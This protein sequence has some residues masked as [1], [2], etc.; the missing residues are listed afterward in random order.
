[1]TPRRRTS[2]PGPGLTTNPVIAQ[3]LALWLPLALVAA[4]WLWQ[5][6]PVG[7]LAAAAML[8]L[9]TLEGVTVAVDQLFGYRRPDHRVGD[10]RAS[11]LFAV[12]TVVTLVPLLLHLRA[13]DRHHH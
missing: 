8:T 4:V 5:R 6:R 12:L 3:D 1:M 11:G 13:L 9:W 7:H 10:A 2:W